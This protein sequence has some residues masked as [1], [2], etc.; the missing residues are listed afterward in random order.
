MN[1]VYLG[2]IEMLELVFIFPIE[3]EIHSNLL[4]YHTSNQLVENSKKIIKVININKMSK[5]EIK[6]KNS[7]F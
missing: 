3:N 2:V 4:T 6:K 5:P 7:F 1:N